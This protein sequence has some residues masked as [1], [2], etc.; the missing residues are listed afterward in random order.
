MRTTILGNVKQVSPE[1]VTGDDQE[2]QISKIGELFTTDW[3]ER[4][5]RAGLMWSTTIGGITAGAA[6]LHYSGGGAGTTV[7]SDQ[8]EMIIGVDAGYYLIPVEIKV[9]ARVNVDAD[10]ETADIIAFADRT[11]APPTSATCE[12]SGGA[13]TFHNLLDGSGSFPGR[14]WTLVST[15]LTDPVCSELLDGVSLWYG[16]AAAGDSPIQMR[17]DYQPV[18]P[19]ALAGP[20]SIVVCWG[21]SDVLGVLAIAKIVV[22]CVP[23]AYLPLT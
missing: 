19:P 16:A 6:V 7:D 20:C 15:D 8:P 9:V 4:L 18:N 13:A 22:A 17:M 2:L 11:Q 21:G 12:A 5:K 10:S 1:V 3:R 23:L 14:G